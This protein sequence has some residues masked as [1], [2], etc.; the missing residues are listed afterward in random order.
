M[1][2]HWKQVE[3][4]VDKSVPSQ[5]GVGCCCGGAGFGLVILAL[6]RFPAGMWF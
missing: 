4:R 3:P 6:L 5:D 1:Q 2:E